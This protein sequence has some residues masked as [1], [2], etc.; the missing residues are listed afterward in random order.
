[1]GESQQQQNIYANRERERE[2]EREKEGERKRERERGR[3]RGDAVDSQSICR[4]ACPVSWWPVFLSS[5]ARLLGRRRLSATPSAWARS[6]PGTSAATLHWMTPTVNQSDPFI[7]EQPFLPHLCILQFFR[8]R[9]KSDWLVVLMKCLTVYVVHTYYAQTQMQS[10]NTYSTCK[11]HRHTHYFT[12]CPT[13]E[14]NETEDTFSILPRLNITVMTRY[15][16]L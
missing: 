16:K 15:A 5:H 4:A 2:R 6:P 1:M 13:A 11:T 3:G 10:V 12:I 9:S 7:H 14:D 8:T